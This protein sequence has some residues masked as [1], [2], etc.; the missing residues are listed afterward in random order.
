[1]TGIEESRIARRLSTIR[2]YYAANRGAG[3]TLTML[4]GAFRTNALVVTSNLRFGLGLQLPRERLVP[5]QSLERDLR[6]RSA[7][8]VFDH[9]AL[10]ILLGQAVDEIEHLH[11]RLGD[12]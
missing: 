10:E 12:R 3:H 8:L 7:P 5:V 9:F 11:R 4:E 1:M 6:G 2:Q